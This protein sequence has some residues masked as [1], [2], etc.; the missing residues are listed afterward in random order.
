[1]M[2]TYNTQTPQKPGVLLR[3]CITFEKYFDI[4]IMLALN[5]FVV[6]LNSYI[7]DF[8]KMTCK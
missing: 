1:M 5:I 2:Y 8:M 3:H 6:I 7:G 4:F